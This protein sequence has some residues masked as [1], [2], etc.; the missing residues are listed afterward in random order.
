MRAHPIRASYRRIQKIGQSTKKERRRY[1]AARALS[2]GS[3]LTVALVLAPFLT[4][5]A[6]AA[7]GGKGATGGQSSSPLSMTSG[8]TSLNQYDPS[9]C[10]SEDDFYERT[11]TGSLNGNFTATEY[12]CD[13][14]VDY[15]NGI[16]WTPGG[17]GVY[18][19]VYVVGSLTDMTITSPTGFV[20]HAVLVGSTTSKGVTTSHYETCSMPPFSVSSGVGGTP[21]PGG[22]WSVTLSGNM[23]A[24]TFADNV[25]MGYVNWQQQGC[26]SSEQ[27]LV[28]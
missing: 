24:V 22:T 14:N 6:S 5:G 12:L 8:Y 18:A 4:P 28:P 19:S 2:I 17:L 1:G 27:N 23:S 11:W 15:Y 13:R 3:L 25:E 21:I 7:K 10:L 26:P 20:Q 9:W 16:W